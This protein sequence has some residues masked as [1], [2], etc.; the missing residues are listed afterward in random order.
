MPFATDNPQQKKAE[1]RDVVA[2]A[3]CGARARAWLM[4][5]RRYVGPSWQ[6]VIQEPGRR[7]NLRAAG[8][9]SVGSASQAKGKTVLEK[10]SAS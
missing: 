2:L 7:S 1:G 9:I 3:V 5:D 10:S 4:P 6:Q 8:Q